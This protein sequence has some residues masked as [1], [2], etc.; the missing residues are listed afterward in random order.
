M[1]DDS[2]ALASTPLKAALRSALAFTIIFIKALLRSS[3]AFAWGGALIYFAGDANPSD[4]IE[5]ENRFSFLFAGAI[6]IVIGIAFMAYN[7]MKARA[8]A[9][10]SERPTP[11]ADLAFDPD[12]AVELY[13]AQKVEDKAGAEPPR[14]NLAARPVFGRRGGAPPEE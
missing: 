3:I 7:L 13:R 4:R 12:A 6:L 10:L 9:K 5:S 1:A 2:P 8:P 14:P 11:A